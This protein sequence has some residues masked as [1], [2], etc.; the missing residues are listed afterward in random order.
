MKLSVDGRSGRDTHIC[1]RCRVY[2]Q[3][4]ENKPIEI[5]LVGRGLDSWRRSMED[6]AEELAL[7]ECAAF[8]NEASLPAIEELA[9]ST[10]MK[11]RQ[12]VYLQK[13]DEIVSK[14][15]EGEASLIKILRDVQAEYEWLSPDA[16]EH[17]SKRLDV[18]SNKVYR[19]A[20]FGKG[21][22]VI[23]RPQ[24][25][26]HICAV[27]LTRHYLNFLQRD[28]C[29]K[30]LPCREGMYRMHQ[31]VSDIARGEGDASSIEL[32]KEMA[33]AI[34]ELAACNQGTISANVIL[35][36]LGDFRDQFQSHLSEKRCPTGTCLQ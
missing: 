19:A 3:W 17:I 28:L 10:I 25:N 15:K 16:L 4:G 35:T 32:V 36:A 23:P 18:P 7:T 11:R 5:K 29:G 1:C 33:Q 9:F 13:L 14:H 21:L 31:I 20:I 22:S 24:A 12:A 2:K 27:D 6:K 8:Q 26:G 34:T 30:C